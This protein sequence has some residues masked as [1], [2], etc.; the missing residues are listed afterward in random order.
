[1]G[2]VAA[3]AQTIEHGDALSGDEIPVGSAADTRL[4]EFKIERGGNSAGLLVKG[5]HPPVTLKRGAIDAT[6]N[7]QPHTFI[8]WLQI[9][10]LFCEALGFL[11][12]IEADV[13][14]RCC[15]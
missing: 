13:Y 5:R 8:A 4:A 10:N 12:R 15:F 14:L 9:E 2:A 7:L 3:D 6:L 11:Y 1:M